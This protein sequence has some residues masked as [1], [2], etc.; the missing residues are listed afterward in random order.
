MIPHPVFIDNKYTRAYYGIIANRIK[1]RVPKNSYFESHH[2]VPESFYATRK[3]VGPAGW[4]PGNSDARSNLVNLTGREHALCHWLLT[5]MTSGV[6]LI[7]CQQAF[8]MMSA[9]TLNQGRAMTRLI[10]R[11]YERNKVEIARIRSDRMKIENPMNDPTARAKIGDSKRGKKRF[12][13]F[14]EAQKEQMRIDRAGEGNGMYGKSHKESTIQRLSELASLRTYSE[15][16]ND[17]RREESS[18]RKEITNG[19]IYKKVKI[20]ELQSWID[21]G[22]IVKGK[23][24][25]KKIVT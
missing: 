25:K 16:T 20:E 22:W 10:C 14:T 6:A 13:V 24:R 23:S 11:A 8:D 7:K 4:L 9:E 1:N 21:Q 19:V 5:K 18:G 12:N 17:K 15:E 2:I 3:R